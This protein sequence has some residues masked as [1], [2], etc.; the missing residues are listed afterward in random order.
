MKSVPERQALRAIQQGPVSMGPMRGFTLT[1]ISI[2]L[3]IIGVILAAVTS[4]GDLLRHASGQR[5]H[6][7]FITGWRN[8]FI[9]YV[10]VTRTVPGDDLAAPTFVIRGRGGAGALCNDEVEATLNDIMLRQGIELPSGRSETQSDR[11]VYQ[12]GNGIAH[13]LRVCFRTVPWTVNGSS[14]GIFATVNRHVMQITGLTPDV[15][16]Q[17]DVLIDGRVDAQFGRFRLEAL[18]SQTAPVS[19]G[20]PSDMDD[21]GAL[22]GGEVSAYFDLR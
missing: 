17:L 18:A 8:A 19:R 3:V 14:T 1:E 4:G 15:A 10:G 20:W 13:E 5:I 16:T 21:A 12:D 9:S 11:Y 2:V 22:T 7:Q 6:S